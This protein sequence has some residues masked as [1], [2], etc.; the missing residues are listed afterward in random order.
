MLAISQKLLDAA[1]VAGSAVATP[2]GFRASG[3][4]ETTHYIKWSEGVGSGTVAIEAAH[5]ETDP[6][7][8]WGW[9]A[10]VAFS[11]TAPK[12]DV[13]RVSGSYRALRHR[14]TNPVVDGTVTTSI[15]GAIG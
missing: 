4:T 3:A 13:V 6:D 5:R 14:I 1:S 9:I 2:A 7:E 12:T 8:R 11:G 10:T 15:V